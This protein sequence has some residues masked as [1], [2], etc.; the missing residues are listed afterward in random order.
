VRECGN[1]LEYGYTHTLTESEYF[2]FCISKFEISLEGCPAQKKRL[3]P[4]YFFHRCSKGVIAL[5]PMMGYFCPE[6]W[7]RTCNNFE[8]FD[9]T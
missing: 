7:H 3:A 1:A 9:C 2:L 8:F 6:R 4:L 5:T